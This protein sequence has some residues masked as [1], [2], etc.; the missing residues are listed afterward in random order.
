MTYRNGKNETKVLDRISL[1]IPAGELIALAGPSGSGKSTLLSILGCILTPTSGLVSI[2]GNDVGQLTAEQRT[3]FRRNRI[4]FVFQRF[5]LIRGLSALENVCIPFALQ[6]IPRE[7]SRALATELLTTVELRGWESFPPARLSGG[8]CQRVAI[9]RA[10]ACAP[11]LVLAD[12]PTASLDGAS[13]ERIMALLRSLSK[14]R[15]VTLIV[16]THDK[17][18]F[19]FADR[20]IFMENGRLAGHLNGKPQATA[21]D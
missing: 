10:L 20:I 5:N 16:V 18:M 14:Q 7:R 19:T 6:G 9:A 4:G 11:E 3:Q 17:R 1:Q 21:P 8:Q 15:G 2:F 13:G 12:E